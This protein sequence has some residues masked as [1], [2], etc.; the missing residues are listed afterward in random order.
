MA[1]FI[2]LPNKE[3]VN[4]DLVFKILRHGKQVKVFKDEK[5]ASFIEFSSEEDSIDY[6]DH[7]E[8]IITY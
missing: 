1:K 2:K 8:K 3:V 6:F 4:L 7:L 5:F